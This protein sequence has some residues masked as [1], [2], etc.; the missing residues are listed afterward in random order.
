MSLKTSLTTHHPDKYRTNA[1]FVYSDENT[2]PVLRLLDAKPGERII[3]LGCGTGELTQKI[4]DIVGDRGD[5]V[6]VDCNNSMLEKA[7]ISVHSVTFSQADI[8]DPAAFGQKY[9][10]YKGSFDAVFSSATLHWCKASPNGAAKLMEWLLKP[11]GRVAVELGG[12]GNI[13][14]VRAALHQA[15][16]NKGVDPI[17]LD[18]W[19]FPTPNQYE[20]VLSS[21]G[22]TPSNFHIVPRPTALPT[23]LKGWLTTF[24]RNSL[25]STF[26]DQEAEKIMDEVVD[27]CRID[28]YWSTSNPWMGVKS[29]TMKEDG[30]EIMYVRLRGTARKPE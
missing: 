8:Q 27:M 7:A 29:E 9:P 2:A 21:A 14:G 17:V 25:L 3:D 15:I 10:S 1:S 18:P 11:G 4:K 19:Y 22:L 30:W 6:G 16:K 28:N 5:V 26:S 20:T 13:C 24:A 23:S 12:F